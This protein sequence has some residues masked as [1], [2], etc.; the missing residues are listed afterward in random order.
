MGTKPAVISSVTQRLL[1]LRFNQTICP[2]LAFV[3]NIGFVCLRI[4]ENVE[5]VSEQLH[6]NTGIL[7]I[8]RFDIKLLCTGNPDLLDRLCLLL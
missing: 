5:A 2:A 3:N 7:R 4:A 8:H 1:I 6:L